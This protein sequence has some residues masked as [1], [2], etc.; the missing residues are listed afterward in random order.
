MKKMISLAV[1]T[2]AFLTASYTESQAVC[3]KPEQITP[4]FMTQGTV[5]SAK[6]TISGQEYTITFRYIGDPNFYGPGEIKEVNSIT[7]SKKKGCEFR[8]R[9]TDQNGNEESLKFTAT[10][11]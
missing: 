4:I 10:R 6:V 5:T 2:T 9:I 1:M 8:A 11:K 7:R 3:P